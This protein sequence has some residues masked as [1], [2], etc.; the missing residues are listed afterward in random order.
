MSAPGASVVVPPAGSAS[1]DA[2][3]G[4]DLVDELRAV[5]L[6]AGLDRIGV[7]DAR[8]L[9][10]TRAAL[11]TR[12]A[13]GLHGGMQFTY[14]NPARSTDPNRALPGV[15]SIVVGAR[16]YAAEI[17]DPGDLAARGP[18][19]RVARYASADSYGSL[20]H[21]LDAV[22]GRLRADGWRA[23]VVL[24]DNALVDRAVA[25]RAGLGWFGK[26]AN[27]LVEG[28][29]SWFVLGSVLTDAPLPVGRTV[30]DGCGPC[31]RCLDGCPTGAIVEPGVVDARRCLAWLVQA[32]GVFPAEHRIALGDRLYG[33][34]T[35]QEVCPPTRR[36]GQRRA[37]APPPAAGAWVDVLD[38]LDADDD[39]LLA[40]HGRWYIP[41]RQPRYLRRNAL[42]VLAN[43]APVPVGGRVAE[44]LARALADD[45]PV[46]RA[47][48]VWA[49]RRLGG[50]DLVRRLAPALDAHDPLVRCEL[51][52]PVARR[53][54][55][56]E[57]DVP[58][59]LPTRLSGGP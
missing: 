4:T 58:V 10:D 23:R 3:P 5:G 21:G 19:A 36:G 25:H 28:E 39:E 48:A 43:T 15:R 34:D 42:L 41:R 20:R 1:M 7:A 12:K 17:P 33:C 6:R 45:D 29:G 40:R 46:V 49:A 11:E 44:V 30:P 26:N 55:D 9:D 51:T 57:G 52:R 32:E 53:G 54:T 37:V 16:S 8:P 31:T 27:L 59:S 47:H 22:A 14:R 35:C 2:V 56:V 18:L 50:D 24:D 13:A 38:L